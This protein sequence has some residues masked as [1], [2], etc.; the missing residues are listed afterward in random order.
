MLVLGQHGVFL[1]V[2][3]AEQI[4]PGTFEFALDHLIDHE[5]DLSALDARFNNDDT[6]ASAYDP[7]VTHK[8]VLLTYSRGLSSS[9]KIEQACTH[10]V[11][12]MA[13][14][15]D[16]EPSYSTSPVSCANSAPTSR[17]CSARP[18]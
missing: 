13:L 2:I 16:S 7:R 8:I 1:P 4:V 15:G 17:P 12:F 3:L 9:R 14:S 5:L 10:N 6:G 11:L 18:C